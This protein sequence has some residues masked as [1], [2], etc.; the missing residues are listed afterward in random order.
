MK[1][2]LCGALGQRFQSVAN[3][4]LVAVGFGGLHHVCQT[5]RSQSNQPNVRLICC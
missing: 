4:G 1:L 3:G 5:S 2:S